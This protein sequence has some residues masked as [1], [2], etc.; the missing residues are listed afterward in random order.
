MKILGRIVLCVAAI[1]GLGSGAPAAQTPAAGYLLKPARVFD[2]TAMREGVVVHVRGDRIAAIGLPSLSL[3]RLD[4]D[5]LVTT[6][7][8]QQ[9]DEPVV[10]AA[11]FQHGDKR[12]AALQPLTSEVLE[13]GVHLL[14]LGG[15]LPG[16]HD[17][18][19]IVTQRD[20]DL[21][22]VLVDSEVPHERG[23][24]VEERTETVSIATG[25]PLLLNSTRSFID[26]NATR[27]RLAFVLDGWSVVGSPA[28]SASGS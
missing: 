5:H 11:H 9:A 24:P 8:T 4:E 14:G 23:S 27:R 16:L 19:V 10:E 7:V 22:C 26:T 6:V 28:A 3:I 15:H 12:F 20:R 21:A 25:K 17:I 13:K 2:G 18:A 1:S